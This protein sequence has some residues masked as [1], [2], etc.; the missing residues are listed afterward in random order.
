MGL[1]TLAMSFESSPQVA[2]TSAGTREP[3]ITPG[4]SLLGKLTEVTFSHKWTIS[5]IKWNW[6]LS[7]S[8]NEQPLSLVPT[9]KYPQGFQYNFI[10]PLA[11]DHILL[12]HQ[13]PLIP[14]V[15]A[16]VSTCEKPMLHTRQVFIA[17]FEYNPSL[18]SILLISYLFF[19]GMIEIFT[20]SSD[21][22]NN[23][24]WVD[25]L[26]LGSKP[27]LWAYLNCCYFL[28]KLQY[29]WIFLTF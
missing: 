16:H 23:M 10:W 17:L 14:G 7:K 3:E 25:T 12:D 9:L 22:P 5:L 11:K 29:V 26:W 1:L 18:L 21:S 28:D 15:F 27:C 6:Y 20:L 8:S 4:S 24:T 13:F 2:L 19:V